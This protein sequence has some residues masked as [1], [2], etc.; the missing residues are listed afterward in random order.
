MEFYKTL[1]GIHFTTAIVIIALYLAGLHIMAVSLGV[2]MS[3]TWGIAFSICVSQVKKDG[4]MVE[5]MEKELE[6]Q[7]IEEYRNKKNH[8]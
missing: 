3:I 2:A 4:D 6:Q 5:K 8:K 1:S 7:D